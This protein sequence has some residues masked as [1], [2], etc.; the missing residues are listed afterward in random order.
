MLLFAQY[1]QEKYHTILFLLFSILLLFCYTIYI[2]FKVSKSI[3]RDKFY[4]FLASL[5]FWMIAKAC[6]L[7]VTENSLIWLVIIIQYIGYF[8][9][10]YSL[11]IF[12]LNFYGGEE[13]ARKAQWVAAILPILGLIIVLTNPIH[14]MFF[15]SL[16]IDHEKRG[17]FYYFSSVIHHVYIIASIF[18]LICAMHIRIFCRRNKKIQIILHITAAISVFFM[19]LFWLQ[20]VGI[21][22][23]LSFLKIDGLVLKICLAFFLIILPTLGFQFLDINPVS[24]QVLYQKFPR[25]IAFMNKKGVINTPNELFVQMFPVMKDG[26]CNISYFVD[27][28]LEIEPKEKEQLKVFLLSELSD[29]YLLSYKDSKLVVKKYRSKSNRYL[30]YVEDITDTVDTMLE[31]EKNNKYLAIM[32]Q[33]LKESIKAKKDLVSTSAKAAV[34][35]N[36][37]DILGH[38]LTVALCTTELAVRDGCREDAI[39]KLAMLEELLSES[40]QDLKNSIQG[41]EFDF[42]QTSLIKA[43]K[44]LSKLK[45]QLEITTQGRPYELNSAQNEA[46]IRICQEA[47][48]NAIK[49]GD[50]KTVHL[51]LRYY[52]K[53]LEI[54]IID[55]GKGCNQVKVG[56][57]LSGMEG[58]VKKLG[59]SFEFGSDGEKGFHIH[60]EIPIIRADK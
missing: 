44:N 3:I 45:M 52:Q 34:A 11:F 35:Q 39:E 41:N 5:F 60:L 28:L 4:F 25:G 50:A 38:S 47:V 42:Q 43:I 9:F 27:S 15:I 26:I 21:L 36:V 29:E 7:V 33:N 46:V 17:M 12:S 49:H 37:H 32:N 1:S 56:Y 54:Y 13:M 16:D 40:V 30:I 31:L 24:Y 55:D 6:R 10:Q 20:T 22:P 48:T 14:H 23:K 53:F 57:G 8:G 59:G 18:I 58:R 51:I 2:S 19:F